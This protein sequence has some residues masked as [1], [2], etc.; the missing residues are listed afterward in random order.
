MLQLSLKLNLLAGA[1]MSYPNGRFYDLV[2]RDEH[3]RLSRHL[4]I[5]CSG[6]VILKHG[7]RSYGSRMCVGLSLS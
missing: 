7:P 1:V 5:V 3:I 6:F 4:V 2:S